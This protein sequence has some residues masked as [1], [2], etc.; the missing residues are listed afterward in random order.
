MLIDRKSIKVNDRAP[1]SEVR[2]F[3]LLFIEYLSPGLYLGCPRFTDKS[4][5]NVFISLSYRRFI[6][7]D[8]LLRIKN[9]KRWANSSLK[10]RHQ[11]VDT[12]LFFLNVQVENGF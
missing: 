1:K 5:A 2:A 11:K 12:K 8:L 7:K 9:I 6:F 4:I 10:V 3:I